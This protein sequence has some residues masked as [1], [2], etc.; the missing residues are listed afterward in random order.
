MVSHLASKH[1]WIDAMRD[2]DHVARLRARGIVEHPERL[3]EVVAAVA[4]GRSILEG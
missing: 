4:M 1:D 3:D 2:E